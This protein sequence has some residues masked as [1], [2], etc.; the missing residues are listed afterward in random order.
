MIECNIEIARMSACCAIKI[1][2]LH[3]F[4]TQC[5]KHRSV[6]PTWSTGERKS[7]YG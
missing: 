6:D 3:D 7:V 1:Q 2:E 4:T 5:L